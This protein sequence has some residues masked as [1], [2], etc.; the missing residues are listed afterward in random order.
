MT[1]PH[2]RQL[3][4]SGAERQGACARGGW[5]GRFLQALLPLLFG[6]GALPSAC[7]RLRSAHES[8]ILTCL[9]IR[10][11]IA[12]MLKRHRAL[13]MRM[14]GALVEEVSRIVLYQSRARIL[15]KAIKI[16]IEHDDI[17]TLIQAIQNGRLYF[18][19][20]VQGYA[21]CH[22]RRCSQWALDLDHAGAYVSA[23]QKARTLQQVSYL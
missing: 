14:E 12:N 2:P 6:A 4:S 19:K 13:R 3:Y 22:C 1:L 9:W 20:G 21:P 15:E 8:A 16:C 18:L 5:A 11:R 10:G 17:P 23:R 7:P